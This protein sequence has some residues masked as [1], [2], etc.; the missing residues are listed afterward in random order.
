[1]GH[2]VFQMRPFFRN[3]PEPARIWVLI[4]VCHLALCGLEQA[5]SIRS[6]NM[7]ACG[8]QALGCNSEEDTGHGPMAQVMTICAKGKGHDTKEQRGKNPG[9]VGGGGLSQKR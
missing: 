1:M 8:Y 3:K 2:S 9:S 5:A 7:S 4:F 6:T